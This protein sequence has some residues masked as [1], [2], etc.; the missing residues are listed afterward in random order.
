MRVCPA[1]W[2]QAVTV[3]EQVFLAQVTSGGVA[4][5]VWTGDLVLDNVY[6]MSSLPAGAGRTGQACCTFVPGFRWTGQASRNQNRAMT[7]VPLAAPW[8]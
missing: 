5:D 3:L 7:T 4:P 8:G 2:P 6:V 1:L